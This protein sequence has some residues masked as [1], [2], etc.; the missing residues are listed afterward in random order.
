MCLSVSTGQTVRSPHKIP[1]PTA[2]G[3]GVSLSKAST[4]LLSIAATSGSYS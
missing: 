4:V 1:N 2:D 3:R